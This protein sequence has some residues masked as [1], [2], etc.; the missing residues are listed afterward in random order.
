MVVARPRANG[1]FFL[2]LPIGCSAVV[3]FILEGKEVRT[4]MVE[5]KPAQGTKLDRKSYQL[6]LLDLWSCN[7]IAARSVTLYDSTCIVTE[8]A[9]SARQAPLDRQLFD[10]LEHLFGTASEI[11]CQDTF[12]R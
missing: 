5:H 3:R 7:Q 6:E 12:T 9:D 11:E 8:N 1:E 10:R 4:M 2:T